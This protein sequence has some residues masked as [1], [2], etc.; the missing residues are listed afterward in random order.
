MT[1]SFSGS[2][3]SLAP[4]LALA[5]GELEDATKSSFNPGFKSKYADL[6]EVLQTIRPVLSKHGLSIVQTIGA[7]DPE[8]KTLQVTTMLLHKSGEYIMDSCNGPVTKPD[9]QGLGSLT[10]Y[11]RR[12]GGASIV[13]VAQDDDDGNAASG[14]AKTRGAAKVAEVPKD[15]AGPNPVTTV[16]RE[17]LEAS[18]RGAQDGAE[19]DK[20]AAIYA[21]MSPPD[22]AAL[23][24]VAKAARARVQGGAA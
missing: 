4:A 3:S 24:P 20:L 17:A 8:R 18:F 19:L 7:Y 2:L 23:L 14:G 5:Q 6:A 9:A 16:T 13:G 21:Q 12:Y 10:T 11:L 15:V 1:M 22:Q